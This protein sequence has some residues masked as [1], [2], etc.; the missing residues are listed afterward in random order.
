MKFLGVG[1]AR[2]RTWLRLVGVN[3]PFSGFACRTAVYTGTINADSGIP[4][5]PC[6]EPFKI[7]QRKVGRHC[8]VGNDCFGRYFLLS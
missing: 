5:E 6:A 7:A 8:L 3:I 2:S 4:L 1:N